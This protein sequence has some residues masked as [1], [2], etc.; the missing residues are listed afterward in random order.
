MKNLLFLIAALALA[1]IAQAQSRLDPVFTFG[2]QAG[3]DYTS[4]SLGKEAFGADYLTGF[5]AG[6]FARFSG[7]RLFLQPELTFRTQRG[8]IQYD[9][10]QSPALSTDLRVQQWDVPVL[11]G[12][13]LVDTRLI[14]LRLLGG[15]VFAWG[16]DTR[17][18]P[19]PPRWPKRPQPISWQAGAGFDLGRFTLDVRYERARLWFWPSQAASQLLVSVGIKLL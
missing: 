19:L 6:A 16:Q 15:P 10:T 5:R 4:H 14:G 11:V 9:P 1:T 3:L 7:R 13:R 12:I 2:P 17:W 18:T 8:S